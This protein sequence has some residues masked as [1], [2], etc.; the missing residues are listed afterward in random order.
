M[1]S[2]MHHI[3]K[4]ILK[5]LTQ[6]A[7]ARFSEM[8]PPRVDSNLYS[9]HLRAL[10]KDGLVEKKAEE[11]R[12]SPKGLALADRASIDTFE[13]R[14]QPKLMCW[15]F[16]QNAKGEILLWPK[17]KQPF[18]GQYSLF[19]GKIHLED[20]TISAAAERDV[21]EKTGQP[22]KGLQHLG[23]CYTR[24]YMNEELIH[25]ALVHVFSVQLDDNALIDDRAVWVAIN[26]LQEFNLSPATQEVIQRVLSG[27][28]S[29]FTEYSIKL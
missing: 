24:V 5:S 12:L 23:D 7:T 26:R 4:Y 6:A 27:D 22:P 2:N 18:I 17:Q 28:K 21:C 11:Y 14:L 10:C 9:Y 19:S 13:T 29:F 8:R 16:I 15:L 20:K 1:L 3:R 25:A